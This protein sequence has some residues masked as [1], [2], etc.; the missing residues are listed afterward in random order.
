MKTKLIAMILTAA[1]AVSLVG[2]VSA[3]QPPAGQLGGGGAN[4]NNGGNN[5]APGQLG[6]GGANHNN[7]N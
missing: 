5:N 6:G 3:D 1:F 2:A 4:H 7:G